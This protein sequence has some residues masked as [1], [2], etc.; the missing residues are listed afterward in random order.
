MT[1]DISR[2]DFEVHEASAISP[3]QRAQLLGLFQ[4]NYRDANPDFIDK[5]LSV[6]GRAAF[7]YDGGEAIGFAM[8]DTRRMDLPRLPDQPVT[9]RARRSLTA[10]FD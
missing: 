9:P 6:L 1:G 8:G 3:L 4:A 7:A 10:S 5:S 2:L